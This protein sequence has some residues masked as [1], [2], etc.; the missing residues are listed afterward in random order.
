MRVGEFI[1]LSRAGEPYRIPNETESKPL[2]TTGGELFR[3]SLA[4][5]HVCFRTPGL[6]PN[7]LRCRLLAEQS[8]LIAW[9][10]GCLLQR[11][12]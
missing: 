12:R 6:L 7:A 2:Y 8:E 9:A 10:R 3:R 11:L 1:C 5:P 4:S